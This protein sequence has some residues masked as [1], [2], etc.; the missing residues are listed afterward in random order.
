MRH[1]ARAIIVVLLLTPGPAWAHD[2]CDPPIPETSCFEDDLGDTLLRRTCTPA[3]W[4][5]NPGRHP[6]LLAYRTGNWLVYDPETSLFE[7]EFNLPYGPYFRLDIVLDGLMNPAGPCWYSDTQQ[8][9]TTF[10]PLLYGPNPVLGRVQIDVDGHIDTGGWIGESSRPQDSLLGNVGRFGYRA[11]SPGGGPYA[12]RTATCYPDTLAPFSHEP[13]VWRGGND[14]CLHLPGSMNGDSGEITGIDKLVGDQDD[15]FETGETWILHGHFFCRA[16]RDVGGGSFYCPETQLMFAHD[17]A[18]DETTISFVFQVHQDPTTLDFDPTNE[19]SVVEI[20]WGFEQMS[21]LIP[22]GDPALDAILWDWQDQ[23]PYD[24]LDSQYWGLEMLLSTCYTS[25]P[26]DDQPFAWTDFAERMGSPDNRPG[27]LT[28]DGVVDAEDAADFASSIVEYDGIGLWDA[29]G[30]PNNGSLTIPNY[31]MNFS[32]YDI[33]YDGIV[34]SEDFPGAIT[35]CNSNG[36]DDC[37]DVTSYSLDLGPG[38]ETAEL[39]A[40]ADFTGDDLPDFVTKFGYP[41][42]SLRLFRNQGDLTFER[43]QLVA[44]GHSEWNAIIAP[45]LDGD[46]DADVVMLFDDGLATLFSDGAGNLSNLLDY[47]GGAVHLSAT[48]A[49]LNADDHVDVAVTKAD[50]EEVVVY[51]NQ[52]DGTLGLPVS[53]GGSGTE[54]AAGDLENDGDID[55]VTSAVILRNQ[56][57]GTFGAPEPHGLDAEGLVLADLDNDGYLDLAGSRLIAFNDRNGSF[58]DPQQH[59]LSMCIVAIDLD[60]DG[61]IDL[62][63][64]NGKPALMNRMQRLLSSPCNWRGLGFSCPLA[65]GDLDLDGDDD[66]LGSGGVYVNQCPA[67][68]SP[69]C[70]N[71]GIPDE[72]EVAGDLDF[73]SDVDLADFQ[74]FAG[75]L[76]GP[77]AF[78][79]PGCHG[80][81]LECDGDVDLAD[82]ALFQQQFSSPE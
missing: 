52:G 70:N 17:V 5:V 67:P 1:L 29:D 13:K 64:G 35:D 47:G 34:T 9:W 20:L 18:A 63:R 51:L 12:Y 59:D 61:W 62:A 77:G 7:G 25:A 30:I 68:R 56:G 37:L 3:D 60:D 50:P 72:C 66:L 10:D 22:T 46:G 65:A 53:L 71:N 49:R 48:A 11:Y 41:A 45:D 54:I 28:G 23:I 15:L 39:F 21:Q 82:F 36:I 42:T 76:G 4:P 40:L 26:A 8:I 81:D 80:A 58:E 78:G 79:T 33:N 2:L 24:Y 38:H 57:D 75:C 74:V 73:D 19:F 16:P 69:D 43:D 55:L 14:V 27:D 32:L 31:P 44:V 6:D